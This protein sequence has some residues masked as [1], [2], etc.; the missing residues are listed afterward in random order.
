MDEPL[1]VAQNFENALEISSVGLDETERAAKNL[2]G[3][4]VRMGG[5]GEGERE[6]ERE[7]E[8]EK[9]REERVERRESRERE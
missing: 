4:R 8:R 2:R 1:K 7:G 9:E 6:R 5:E 3:A